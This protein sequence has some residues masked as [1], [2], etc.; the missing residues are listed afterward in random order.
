MDTGKGHAV[1]KLI[2]PINGFIFIRAAVANRGARPGPIIKV[3]NVFFLKCLSDPSWPVDL[4]VF[5]DN[6]INLFVK[7]LVDCLL[8]TFE[9]KLIIRLKL[10]LVSTDCDMTKRGL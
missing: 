4:S 2:F 7:H 8:R 9:T 10:A 5:V 1:R 3:F 6:S